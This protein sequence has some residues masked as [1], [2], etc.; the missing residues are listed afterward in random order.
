MGTWLNGYLVLQGNIHFST[1]QFK[2]FLKLL[3]RKRLGTRWAKYLFSRCRML[4]VET[5]LR[6]WC[7]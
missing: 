1:A 2:L 3:A 5:M 6:Y 4:F 7:V